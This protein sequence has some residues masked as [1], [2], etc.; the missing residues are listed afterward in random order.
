[1][2]G[3]LESVTFI[4]ES[5]QIGDFLG[6]FERAALFSSVQ[7]TLSRFCPSTPYSWNPD[8]SS[9]LRFTQMIDLDVES[10]CDDGC[11]SGADDDIVI[12]PSQTMPRLA[13]LGLGGSP[14][15]QPTIGVTPKEFV[16]LANQCPNFC[17]LSIHFQADSLNDPAAIPGM[18]HNAEPAA[19]RTNC[20]L[21]QFAAD[22]RPVPEG[23]AL[24]IALTLLRIS[25]RIGSIKFVNEEWE[26]VK[27]AIR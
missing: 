15:S 25:P 1:M 5:E 26:E 20:T 2:L 7:K 16:A 22:E 13:T 18:I 3:K 14:C 24:A 6:A 21:T 9:L 19:S 11:S 4:P 8:C 27:N 23:P 17:L 12:S 10:L